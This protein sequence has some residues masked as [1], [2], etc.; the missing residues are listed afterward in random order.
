[1]NM[2]KLIIDI[3]IL[4]ICCILSFLIPFKL[5]IL[6]KEG[7]E[8]TM[9][10]LLLVL[11]CV[12]L[13]T[14]LFVGCIPGITPTP[15]PEEP[16]PV[17]E[18]NVTA[19]LVEVE[20]IEAADAVEEVV[21]EIDEVDVVVVEAAEAVEAVEGYWNVD[22]AIVNTGDLFIREYILTF[23]VDYPNV[24]K[25]LVTFDVTGKYLEIGKFEKGT[26]KLGAYGDN[27]NPE[28]VSV[29]WELFE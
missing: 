1:M 16:A 10:K 17:M 13:T 26:V 5:K 27:E 7:G 2:T 9:K 12:V 19:V 11:A 18:A 22:W 20:A 23:T 21:V 8:K 28:S 6:E 29:S 25:D 14:M 15:E 24:A 4:I 3:F